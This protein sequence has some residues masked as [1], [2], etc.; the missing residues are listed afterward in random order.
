MKVLGVVIAAG[1]SSR[2]GTA[3]ALLQLQERTVLERVTSAL[4]VGGCDELFVVCGG[5]YRQVIEQEAQRLGIRSVL[6][7]DGAP[8]IL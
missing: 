4:D 2:F 3:K 6:N 1:E 7:E 8:R 5:S